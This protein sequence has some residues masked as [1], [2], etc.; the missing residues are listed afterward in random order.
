VKR[1]GRPHLSARIYPRSKIVVVDNTWGVREA[2]VTA[3][4]RGRIFVKFSIVCE[5]G[6]GLTSSTSVRRRDET[7][8]WARVGTIEADALLAAEALR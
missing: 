8:T 4:R 6:G 5:T 1:P 7:I 2:M 3:A